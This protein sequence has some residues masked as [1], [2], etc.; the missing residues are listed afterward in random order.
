MPPDE[1]TVLLLLCSNLAIDNR[2]ALKPLTL[3]EWNALEPKIHSSRFASP[4]NLIGQGAA[5][6]QKSL[7]LPMPDAERIALLLSRQ[8]QVQDEINY[9]A[10]RGIYVISRNETGYP[11]RYLQRLKQSTPIFIY[12]SGDPD[13]LGQPGI[14]VVGSRNVDEVGQEC[15]AWLGNV[16]GLSGLVLYSGGARGVDSLSM[17]AALEARGSVVGVL[18][19]S[20][21]Q[22]IRKPQVAAQL[23]TGNLCLVTP[24]SPDAGFSVGAAMGRN[25]LIYCLA[26]Y[27]LVIAS[28]VEKGGTWAGAIET[29]KAGWVPVFVLDHDKMP[30]GNRALLEKGALS[31]PYPFNESYTNLPAWLAEHG[32]AI[33]PPSEQLG[34]L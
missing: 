30:P 29:L 20:L 19:D 24:Y 1:T 25:K 15:A 7:D 26:D 17:E 9:L 32:S 16:C 11:G 23:N 5:E 6:I 22:E 33:K 12:Y 28:E 27:A 13:L 4:E 3:R 31:F 21:T 14:A 34:F 2:S 10:G 18:A 8:E